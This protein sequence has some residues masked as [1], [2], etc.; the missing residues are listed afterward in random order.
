MASPLRGL[1]SPE[2][3]TWPRRSSRCGRS[4]W[5]HRQSRS[6]SRD[7]RRSPLPRR[8]CRWTRRP[9]C[10]SSTNTGFIPPSMHFFTQSAPD[11]G[12]LGTAHR[13]GNPAVDLGGIGGAGRNCGQGETQNQHKATIRFTMNLQG[14]GELLVPSTIMLHRPH[15]AQGRGLRVLLDENLRQSVS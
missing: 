13:V 3:P 7:R 5:P 14:I 12:V 2:E 11:A 6:R 8:G 4:S 10:D 9:S 15:I 1:G